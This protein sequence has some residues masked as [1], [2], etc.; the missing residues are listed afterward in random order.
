MHLKWSEIV[1]TQ[2]VSQ[3]DGHVIAKV[4]LPL[5]DQERGTVI[6]LVTSVIR[7]EIIAPY[8]IRKWDKRIEVHDKDAL[9][10]A[11]EI[12]R[13]KTVLQN[14]SP[15]M[16]KWVETKTGE[17]LGKIIDC[18]IDTN[19]LELT[20]LFVAKQWLIFR[21]AHVL[22]PRKSIIEIQRKKVIVRER[23]VKVMKSEAERARVP[24]P[25]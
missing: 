23:G 4:K 25:A 21:Y 18:E 11:D 3:Q 1:G 19:R 22:I 7:R 13:V 6:A 12:L 5:L 9:V 20:K 24:M 10:H 15:L 8:D 14:Y 2:V 16:G 17:Y